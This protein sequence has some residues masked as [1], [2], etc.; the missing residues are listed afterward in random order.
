MHEGETSKISSLPIPNQ[1][2]IITFMF[3]FIAQRHKIKDN[4]L[5]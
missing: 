1:I 4:T 5:G 2:L 3:S